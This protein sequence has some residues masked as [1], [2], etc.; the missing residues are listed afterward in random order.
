MGSS[1]KVVDKDHGWRR[2]VKNAFALRLRPTCKVGLFGD[3]ARQADGEMT[4]GALALLHEFGDRRGPPHT[5]K[6]PF[7][8]PT[9][10]RV[11][12]VLELM[13]FQGVAGIVVGDTSPFNVLGRMGA[14]LAAETKKTITV[15]EGVL[16]KNAPSTALAKG[17]RGRGGDILRQRTLKRIAKRNDPGANLGAALKAAGILASVRPLVDTGAMVGAITWA[18]EQAGVEHKGEGGGGADQAAA[19]A[20]G[21]D[22]G[23][24]HE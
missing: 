23:G 17:M 21:G 16:P 11:E 10:D 1:S 4:V 2:I 13:A 14:F 3:G 8:G 20:G 22:S 19:A 5:P 7:L 24:G 12:P 18:V 6:R 9:F 15:G